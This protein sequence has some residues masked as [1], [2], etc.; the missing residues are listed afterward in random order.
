MDDRQ[1]SDSAAALGRLLR[2]ACDGDVPA[3]LN[4][5]G[6]CK[7]ENLVVRRS[8]RPIRRPIM[9]LAAAAL[10]VAVGVWMIV[11]PRA[12]SVHFEGP[13]ATDGRRFN[14]SPAASHAAV[15]FSD[16]SVVE[17]KPGTAG[18][19]VRIGS[20]G[21]ELAIED[22]SA[23]ARITH[24]P[25]ARW[26]LLA[27]PVTIRVTGT[28][29]DVTWRPTAGTFQVSLYE[30]SVVVDGPLAGAPFALHGGQ[31]LVANVWN[32]KVGIEELDSKVDA[33]SEWLVSPAGSESAPPSGASAPAESAPT[34]DGE[35]PK[36]WTRLP[37]VSW[38]ELMA[39]GAYADVLGQAREM[40]VETCLDRCSA[41]DL[42]ALGDAARYGRDVNLAKRALLAQ[43]RRFAGS[44]SAV[45]AAFLL[46]RMAEDTERSPS[47]AL[48][49]YDRYLAEAPGGAFA[50][51]TL[52]RKMLL[53]A[54][55][56]GREAAEPIAD[57]YLRRF[58]N[59]PYAKPAAGILGRAPDG[60]TL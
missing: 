49:W 19:L 51:E 56:S 45:A 22:G 9:L 21:A 16:A 5:H 23:R 46:G 13:V 24:K 26:R 44:A 28:L 40:G 43:R 32:K 6:R 35:P 15:R 25:G 50:A 33:V 58:P 36:D 42:S 31:K 11:R 20:D 17:L 54:K 41:A 4:E 59:G 55:G 34:L 14:V 18:S 37:R 52:G 27:G 2:Q 47:S 48:Q 3:A 30:G 1:A 53:V 38:S 57:S 60:G 7:V 12:L 39:Q 10:V 29:F 8:A